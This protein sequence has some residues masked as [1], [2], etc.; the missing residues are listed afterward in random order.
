MLV[1]VEDVKVG[2]LSR[3]LE[4]VNPEAGPVPPGGEPGCVLPARPEGEFKL[5]KD[6]VVIHV[7]S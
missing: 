5:S 4:H 1:S 3:L 6:F 2:K 7:H